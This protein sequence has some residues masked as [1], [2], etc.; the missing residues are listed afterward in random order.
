MAAMIRLVKGLASGEHAQDLI[1][2]ALLA[3]LI[4]IVAIVGVNAVGD[5]VQNVLW[6]AVSA[7][8][9]SV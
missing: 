2:Y 3:G 8:M 5:A 6:S 1:E 9:A 4:A 7:G